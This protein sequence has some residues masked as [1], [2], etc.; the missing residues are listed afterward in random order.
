MILTPK[1]SFLEKKALAEAHRD[2][3]LSTQFRESLHA[4]LLDHVLSLPAT[5]DPVAAA[6]AYYNIMGAREYINRLLNIAE[7]PKSAPPPPPANLDH[8]VR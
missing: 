1:Q 3:V 4:A 5:T 2:L 6:A 7:Q 8:N